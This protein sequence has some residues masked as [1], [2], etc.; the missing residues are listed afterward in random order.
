MRRLGTYHNGKLLKPENVASFKNEDLIEFSEEVK[1]AALAEQT[2]FLE[3]TIAK[4]VEHNAVGK[5]SLKLDYVELL[6]LKS[7]LEE[8]SYLVDFENSEISW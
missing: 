2:N 5:N 4:I 6:T 8:S 3:S 1:E 7:K